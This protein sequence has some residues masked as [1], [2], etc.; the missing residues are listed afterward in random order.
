MRRSLRSLVQAFLV[1]GTLTLA[2]AATS[3][4]E[5]FVPRNDGEVLERLP[6]APL[7]PTAQRLRAMRNQL[8]VRA[9][10][11]ALATSAAWL[12]IEQG[13]ALSDPRYYGYAQGVLAPWWSA[14]EPPAPIRVLRATIRQHDHDFP[15]ALDDLA[16]ALRAD[17]DNAQAWLTQA[18]V[19][20]VRG[21]YDGAKRS[22]NAV[23][24]LADPLVAATCLSN[25]DSLTGGAPEAYTMLRGALARSRSG[26]AAR[27]WALTT[28]AEIAAR[29]GQPQLA[30]QH[31]QAALALAGNDDY[32]LAAY[33]DFLLD[34]GRPA[35]VRAL[36]QGATRADALLLR[37]ALADQALGSTA[38][39]ADLAG[40]RDRFAAARLRGDVVHRREE[41]RFTLVLLA[42]PQAA[43]ALARDNWQV[44]REPWDARILLEAAVASGDRQAALPVIDFL[45]N[46]GIEDVTLAALA[47]RLPQATR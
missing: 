35:A 44:Q 26:D 6:V 24:Q 3:R 28:L 33:A 14:A 4:A 10:N 34:Q 40:L 11:L 2:S 30:D 22:C 39:A 41:A 1:T 31:F 27:R 5:P 7:D 29:R 47:A 25:V 38:L 32:L 12:Y 19:Q 45:S 36:L 37:L 17:P 23:L 15:G 43:L 42:Q 16:H 18:T 46:T 13:R 8:A 21:D 9:D 20:L